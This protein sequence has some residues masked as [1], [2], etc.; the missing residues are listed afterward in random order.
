VLNMPAAVLKG[1]HKMRNIRIDADT[2]GFAES[3]GLLWCAVDN[4]STVQ[5]RT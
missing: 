4:W 3:G 1:L 5:P 2:A